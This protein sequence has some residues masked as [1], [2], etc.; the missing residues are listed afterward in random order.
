MSITGK[1]N[2]NLWPKRDCG[3][4]RGGEKLSMTS[5]KGKEVGDGYSGSQSS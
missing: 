3:T 2:D 5:G 4:M 1:G